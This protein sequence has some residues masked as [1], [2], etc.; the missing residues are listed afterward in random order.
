MTDPTAE[1]ITTALAESIRA[2][3][4]GDSTVGMVGA[5]TLIGVYH[6]GEGDERCMF[7][8]PDAQPLRETLGLL[9]VGQ[10]V[11]QEELRRWVFDLDDE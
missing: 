11:W 9:S 6:D 5:W 10:A 2:G 8:T 1:R 7:L 4:L 3:E